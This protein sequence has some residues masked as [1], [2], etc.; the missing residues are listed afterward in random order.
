MEIFKSLA[1]SFIERMS[2][3]NIG[4]Y[5]SSTAFFFLL[6]LVPILIIF[7]ALLSA[8]GLTKSLIMDILSVIPVLQSNSLVE[9]IIDEAFNMSGSL[10][11][12]TIVVLVWSCSKGMLALMYGFNE[13]YEVKKRKNY[14]YL[15]FWAT[16]YTLLLIILIIVM[17]VFM[18]FGNTILEFL[19]STI[20]SNWHLAF[21]FIFQFRYLITIGS[22][23]LLLSFLY[24]MI[25]QEKNDFLQQIPG[26]VFTVVAWTIFSFFFSLFAKVTVYSMY[27]G[28]LAAVIIGMI[29]LYWCI[30]LLMIGGFIN[31]FFEDAIYY[32]IDKL[33]NKIS[34]KRVSK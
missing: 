33:K 17:L 20:N 7:S 18:V 4:A 27:Y 2:K 9:R 12:I 25:P 19:E 1:R 24:K 11:P 29:W 3:I 28:S 5:A 15:R 16:L 31:H 21:L 10:L 22:G 32:Y 34:E 26:A 13:I 6:S 8:T 30:Y 23:V 14:F